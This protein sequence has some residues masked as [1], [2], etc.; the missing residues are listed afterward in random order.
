MVCEGVSVRA[1][2]A[3]LGE[4]S[5]EPEFLPALENLEQAAGRLGEAVRSLVQADVR[6]E[7]PGRERA[8]CQ[9]V[10]CGFAEHCHAAP[11]AC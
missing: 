10:H 1:G 7:W 9:T 8:A 11:G 5:S 3:F 2:V 4:A 6:G